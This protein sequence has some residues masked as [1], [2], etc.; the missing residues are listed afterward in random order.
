MVNLYLYLSMSTSIQLSTN[1]SIYVCVYIYLS[2]SISISFVMYT[3]IYNYIYRQFWHIFHQLHHRSYLRCSCKIAKTFDTVQPN[4]IARGLHFPLFLQKALHFLTQRGHGRGSFLD[5]NPSKSATI[6]PMATCFSVCWYIYILYI[7]KAFVQPYAKKWLT[8]SL[9]GFWQP[10]WFY[11]SN[12]LLEGSAKPRSPCAYQ[13]ENPCNNHAVLTFGSW[14]FW[15]YFQI[16]VH[17][18]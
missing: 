5:T 17:W 16:S 8:V 15:R 4:C 18:F 14:S 9:G 10:I 11:D 6:R 12:R 1:L 3:Y 13:L 2:M 7:Y